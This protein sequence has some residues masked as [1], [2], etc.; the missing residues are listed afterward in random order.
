M[1]DPKKKKKKAADTEASSGK[2]DGGKQGTATPAPT[3]ALPKDFDPKIATDPRSHDVKPREKAVVAPGEAK[4]AKNASMVDEAVGIAKAQLAQGNDK[5]ALEY[6]DKAVKKNPKN[7]EVRILRAEVRVKR[8][9]YSEAISDLTVAKKENK[10]NPSIYFWLGRA[11]QE[12]DKDKE[13]VTN[14]DQCIQ[15]KSDWADA[16]YWRGFSYSE[17]DQLKDKACPDYAKAAELGSELGT[18]AK[19]KYCK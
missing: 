17:L 14:F 18:K 10:T 5:I 15:L 9:M 2:T 4:Y 7:M 3:N 1:F 16:Y 8:K 19:A 13:A 11:K 6:L 12:Q